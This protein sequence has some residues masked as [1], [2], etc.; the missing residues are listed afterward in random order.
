M[1]IGAAVAGVG[2]MLTVTASGLQVYDITRSTFAVGLVGGIALVPMIVAGLW[3]GMLADA[4]DRKLLLAISAL[5]AWLSTLGLVALS[6]VDATLRSGGERVE[7]WPF[8]LLTTLTAVSATVQNA[9]RQAIVPRLLP[10]ELVSRAAALSGIAIGFQVTIG[11]AL[12]GVLVA[13][14]GFA[15]TFAV[16]AALFLVGFAGILNLPRMPPL[17]AAARPGLESLR[18]GIR[19]LRGAPNIRMSFLVDLVAMT[20]GR[21]IALLPAVGATVVGGGAITVGVLTAAA[22]V[23]TFLTSLLSG[24][25]AHVHRHG[26]AIGR[27]IAV[28]GGFVMLFGAVILVK[29]VGGFPAVGEPF[30]RVDGVALGVAALAM[31]GMGASDE[32]SAIFRSTMLL[33]AAPDDMRGRLQGVFTV[34]VTGGPRVGDLWVALTA[35]AV[36]LWFP[37]LVGGLLIV[38]L[39]GLLLRLTPSFRAY[40]A[41][42][43]VR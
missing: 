40:D 7:V 38:A 21:P 2:S 15:W 12:A 35:S 36:A 32:V 42:T 6:A 43:P 25:V 20:F 30:A 18:E 39:I 37:A 11:P 13:T 34:V 8:Y 19:F 10:A 33:T 41:R 26:V 27:A 23:G 17:A 29:L 16:D 5:L 14:V 22:A 1:W 28:Y 4:T 31:V 3:G 9:T 24:P